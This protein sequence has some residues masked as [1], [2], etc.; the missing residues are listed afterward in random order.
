M[1]FVTPS[2]ESGE[3]GMSDENTTEVDVNVKSF[4][5]LLKLLLDACPSLENICEVCFHSVY[6]F[7]KWL[8]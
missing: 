3:V 8:Y 5:N 2:I 4:G 1:G 7:F 6:V